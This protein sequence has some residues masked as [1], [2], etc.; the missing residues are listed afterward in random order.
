MNLK[1]C[2]PVILLLCHLFTGHSVKCEESQFQLESRAEHDLEEALQPQFSGNPSR[3]AAIA[4]DIARALNNLAKIKGGR[5]ENYIPR[6]FRHSDKETLIKK[7]LEK[8][9]DTI[10]LVREAFYQNPHAPGAQESLSMAAKM[11]A[12]Q[13][14][15]VHIYNS[16]DIEV[17]PGLPV[18]AVPG[19]IDS[20]TIYGNQYEATTKDGSVYKGTFQQNVDENGRGITI[21]CPEGSS[22]A[23]TTLVSPTQQIILK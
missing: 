18:P 2:I 19:K 13:N 12:I 11:R 23:I 3:D 17:N 4:A 22:A 7:A 5:P 21:T 8:G 9:V 1:P 15:D 10:D 6:E 20:V 14:H 16:T